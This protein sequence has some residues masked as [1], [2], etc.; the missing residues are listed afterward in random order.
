MLQNQNSNPDVA[1]AKEVLLLEQMRVRAD[2]IVEKVKLIEKKK[3]ICQ[4]LMSISRYC[5]LLLQTKAASDWPSRREAGRA[6]GSVN[7]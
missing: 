1:A 2:G 3:I 5:I 6:S 4:A 7:N